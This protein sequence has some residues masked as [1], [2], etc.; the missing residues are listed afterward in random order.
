MRKKLVRL[1]FFA[2][3]FFAN[4]SYAQWEQVW[5][6]GAGIGGVVGVNEAIHQALNSQFCFSLLWL[7]GIAPHWSAEVNAGFGKISSV[8]QGGYSEY[9]TYI[10]PYDIRVRYAPFESADWQPYIYAGIGLLS[11][12]VSSSSP[13][14]SSDAKLNGSTAF[15]PLG[16][17]IYHSIDKNWSIEASI[18]ENPSFTD[19]LNPV[20]DDR[21]DAFWGFRIGISYS[22][23][24]GH[25]QAE[26]IVEFDLGPRGTSQILMGITFD[27]ALGRLRAESEKTLTQVLTSLINHDELE[28]EFRS[29]TDNSGDFNTSMALT[30]DRAE[31]IKVWL[32]S[33]GIS[34]SRITTQGYGPHNPLVPNTSP[35]NKE[36]NQRIE[37]VRMK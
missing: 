15:L 16:I 25:K 37:I 26:T 1:F 10:A 4:N 28:V 22:F 21:N 33:R 31:A 18:G 19:N 27:S 8:T 9:S 3:I 30:H 2:I 17:G 5:S 36:K 32:V 23:S 7:N 12:N 14:A 6:F 20:H 35:E 13:Q 29:Y 11:Y 34:A 24:G